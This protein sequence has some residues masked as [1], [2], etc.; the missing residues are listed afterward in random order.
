[1]KEDEC[2]FPTP[3]NTLYFGKIS[4]YVLSCACCA[5]AGGSMGTLEDRQFAS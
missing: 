1:M 3:T 4:S 5:G 2:S